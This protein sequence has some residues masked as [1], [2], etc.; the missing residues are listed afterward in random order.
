MLMS[1]PFSCGDYVVYPNHGVGRVKAIEEQAISGCQLH[2]FVIEFEKN[3]MTLRVPVT[4][5]KTA[6]LRPLA[7]AEDIQV[8]FEVLRKK[9]RV[10]KSV[11]ARRAQEYEL[12]INS[13]CLKSIAEVLRELH[14]HETEQSYSERQ[15]YHAALSRMCF[16]ISLVHQCDESLV[17]QE[18]EL[19]LK[20]L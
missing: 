9:L 3:R 4:K 8:A 14:R 12:K 7:T 20:A 2:V 15:V 1:L 6:G 18:I 17:A 16:E 11:W 10:K 19:R 13:G 5:A